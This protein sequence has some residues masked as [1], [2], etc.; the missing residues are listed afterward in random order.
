M[1]IFTLKDD[2]VHARTGRT[3]DGRTYEIRE[4][5]F[6]LHLGDEVR[7]VS[8]RLADGK[9][10]YIKGVYTLLDDSFTTDHYGNVVI[11]KLLLAPYIQ[12]QA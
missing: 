7:A 3:K 6:L 12:K 9:P 2:A 10:A 1:L 4:Q 11:Q 5:R 8:V